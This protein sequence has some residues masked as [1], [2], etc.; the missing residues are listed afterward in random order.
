M[1]LEVVLSWVME[2]ALKY[3]FEDLRTEIGKAFPDLIPHKIQIQ[4]EL[5]LVLLGHLRGVRKGRTVMIENPNDLNKL[6]VHIQQFDENYPELIAQP[7]CQTS[8]LDFLSQL[9]QLEDLLDY[10]GIS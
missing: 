7:K 4:N 1:S 9:Q 10:K 3:D 6:K 2:H 5:V 8:F